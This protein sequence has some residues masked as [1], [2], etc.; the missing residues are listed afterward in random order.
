[1]IE[2]FSDGDLRFFLPKQS[3][4]KILQNILFNSRTG[5]AFFMLLM[6][7]EGYNFFPFFSMWIL[8]ICTTPS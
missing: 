8:R 2:G 4:L 5:H 6:V 1:M 7:M 3:V